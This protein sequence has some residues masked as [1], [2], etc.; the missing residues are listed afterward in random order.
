MERLSRTVLVIFGLTGDLSKRKLLP[1]LYH[2]TRRGVLPDGFRV[3]GISRK[4]TTVGDVIAVVRDAVSREGPETDTNGRDGALPRNETLSRL[5][6]MLSILD[7][8]ISRE[9]DYGLLARELD[10]IDANAGEPLNR[11]FYLAIPANLFGTVTA[12]LG[13][14]DIN[15]RG[16]EG[17]ESRFLIEKPFGEN[18]E[19]AR[20]LIERL[21]RDFDEEQIFRIDHYLAKETAQNILAFR[22]GNPLFRGSWN[23][24]RVRAI[25]ISANESIGIEGRTA[26]Y[27]RMGALRDLVQ[28][29]LLQLLALVTMR[30][31]DSMDSD[32]IHKAKEELLAKVVPPAAERMRDDTVRGQYASYRDETGKVGSMTETYA[33]LRLSI[34]SDEWRGVPV[35]LRTGKMLREKVTEINMVFGDGESGNCAGA[36]AVAG[37]GAGADAVAGGAGDGGVTAGSGSP[38]FGECNVLTIRI[39]PNEGIAVDL[40]IK[41]PGFD[42]LFD[43]VQLDYCYRSDE[44]AIPDAYERVLVDGMRGDRTL[45]ASANE[46]LSCWRISNPILDAWK[47]PDFPLH[48]Y[49]NGSAGPEAANALARAAGVKWL[50]ET[51]LVCP[52]P[53]ARN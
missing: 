24:D 11:L 52:V 13:K 19:T 20:E 35:L 29:H 3:L 16:P 17:R 6:S 4:G 22:F 12:R 43:D 42:S 41:K 8:D 38:A 7:M 28:S 5:E 2:L 39:Q 40:R 51:H 44:T 10:R 27:E 34:D 23:R 47:E 46:V 9:G 36:D 1:A 31:P 49:E 14:P 25:M 48:V 15:R 50:D 37:D 33:A 32:S 18:L 21:D 45:F 53:R 26:F 30:R